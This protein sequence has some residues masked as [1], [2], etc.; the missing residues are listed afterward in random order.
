LGTARYSPS[1]QAKHQSKTLLQ[2]QER[3][4]IAQGNADTAIV[5]ANWLLQMADYTYIHQADSVISSMKGQL[6]DEEFPMYHSPTTTGDIP[7]HLPPD[8]IEQIEKLGIVGGGI[9][10]THL[11][12]F[13]RDGSLYIS[14][15]KSDP[16]VIEYEISY[17]PFNA[18]PSTDPVSL[19]TSNYNNTSPISLMQKGSC[20]EQRIDAITVGMKYLFHVRARNLAG[21]GVWSYP[22]VGCIEG[23]PLEI[24]YTGEIVEI[25]MPKDGVYSIL[26]YGAKAADGAIRKG[27]RGAIVGA[28]F[29]LKR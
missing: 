10:P 22:V 4:E 25:V 8:F 18:P 19:I 24:E 16:T 15:E 5:R 13:V 29:K 2:Q 17:E 3:L 7:M 21:W 1:P 9:M 6:A 20:T 23:F 26:A 14:W 27:G 11:K 28:K 12:S